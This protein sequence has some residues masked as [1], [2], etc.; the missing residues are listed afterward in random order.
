MASILVLGLVAL[1]FRRAL[2]SSTSAESV[3]AQEPPPIRQTQAPVTINQHAAVIGQELAVEEK[4]PDPSWLMPRRAVA[5]PLAFQQLDSEFL[6][7]SQQQVA[8]LEQIRARFIE[9]IGGTNQ[10]PD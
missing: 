4:P 8:A 10:S 9:Q 7:L 3:Q 1:Q 5:M 6:H 2:S